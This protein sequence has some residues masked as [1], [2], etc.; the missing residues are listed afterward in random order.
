MEIPPKHRFKFRKP[1]ID[2]AGSISLVVLEP[3]VGVIPFFEYGNESFLRPHVGLTTI[4]S[5]INSH[6]NPDVPYTV[7]DDITLSRSSTIPSVLEP[8]SNHHRSV[9]DTD[10]QHELAALKKNAQ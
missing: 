9:T 5:L 10:F 2:V 4:R 7:L 1:F 8:L 3:V 6:S